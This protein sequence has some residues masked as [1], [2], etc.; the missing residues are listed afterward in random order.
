MIQILT[1]IILV[2]LQTICAKKLMY[3]LNALMITGISII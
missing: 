1:S 3:M 2:P